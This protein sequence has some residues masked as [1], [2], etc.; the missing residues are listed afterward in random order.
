MLLVKN[1]EQK[2]DIIKT[3]FLILIEKIFESFVSK[4]IAIY[5]HI[6]GRIGIINLISLVDIKLI[7]K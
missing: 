2:I 6:T 7:I 1:K 4:N 3:I 5:I